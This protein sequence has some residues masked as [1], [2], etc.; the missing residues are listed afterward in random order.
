MKAKMSNT[1][2]F[3]IAIAAI[4][5]VATFFL[6]TWAIYLIAPQ[7]PEGLSMQ[8]WL[9]KITGQVEI[10]NGLN[11][12]IGMKTINAEMFPEFK[13]LPFII[14]FFIL[15][16][17]LVAVTGSRKL[18]LSYLV[19]LV[20]FG[21]AALVDF[22]MWGYDYGHNLDPAAAIQVPGFS[23]QPPVIGH[24]KLLNFDAFSYPD[25]GAW[26][27]IA[28]AVI[29]G[30][31]WF[32]EKRKSKK[33]VNI[34]TGKK[35][36]S[37]ATA[38][39]ACVVLSGCTPKSEPIEYGK[40][41]CA[42]CRMTIMDP[43]F[44]GEIVSKKGKVFK[45]DDAQCMGKFMDRRAIELKDIHQTLFTNY[46]GEHEFVNVTDAHFVVGSKLKSPMGS[47]AA[48]F[49]DKS[50]ADKKAAEIDGKVTSWATLFNV[51]Q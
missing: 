40:D 39:L 12:Y 11:H 15:Y 17:L 29:C 9:N 8:I 35:S 28:A 22:Y 25:T 24:K 4:A 42:E 14:G 7:Y 3:I 43:K 32:L 23:Y 30:V 50:S 16:G 49:A 18:L 31:V 34:M 5:M 13:I 41:N 21:I 33:T 44:G 48:A 6:P 19:L 46:T 2:R 45:F 37:I 27:V 47:N 1:S 38:V 20:L 51:L 26:F 36:I 10:I